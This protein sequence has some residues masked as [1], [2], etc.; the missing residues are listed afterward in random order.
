ML[1]IIMPGLTSQATLIMRD[2]PL[3]FVIGHFEILTSAK[4]AQ[5]FTH[6]STPLVGAVAAY[7]VVLLALQWC[8]GRVEA[9]TRRKL[10]A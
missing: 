2:L 9:A 1:L 3:A 10:E 5:V 7:A 4:A 8:T 6:N